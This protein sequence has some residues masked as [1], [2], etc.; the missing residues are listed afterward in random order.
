MNFGKR[1]TYP[2]FHTSKPILEL[3]L[4]DFKGRV[5]GEMMEIELHRFLRPEKK[6]STEEALRE[7]IRQDVQAARRYYQT[8]RS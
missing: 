3:H 2:E 1:P 5:Y 4:L 7:K 6:F 8:R